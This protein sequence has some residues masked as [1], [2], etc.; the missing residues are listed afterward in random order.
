MK[1]GKRQKM[2][3]WQNGKIMHTLEEIQEL[4]WYKELPIAVKKAVDKYPPMHVYRFKNSKKEFYIVAYDE[5]DP[6]DPN[7]KVTLRVQKSGKGGALAEIGMGELDTN[8]V[9]GVELDSIELAE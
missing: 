3:T 1:T 5:E 6:L 2:L 7:T 4:E 8:Q 9:F